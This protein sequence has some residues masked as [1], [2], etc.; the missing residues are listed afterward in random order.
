MA[1]WT[2][3]DLPEYTPGL[4]PKIV[5]MPLAQAIRGRHKVISTETKAWAAMANMVEHTTTEASM[6]KGHNEFEKAWASNRLHNIVAAAFNEDHTKAN[7]AIQ[8]MKGITAATI[9]QMEQRPQSRRAQ[10]KALRI[11][12]Q[13]TV[14]GK[15]ESDRKTRLE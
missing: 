2:K 12:M 6:A 11:T 4:M 13:E 8:D 7:K 9:Q 14:S 15:K 1:E 3:A 10:R 5:K